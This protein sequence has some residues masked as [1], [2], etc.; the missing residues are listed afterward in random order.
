MCSKELNLHGVFAFS[1]PKRIGGQLIGDEL[2]EEDFVRSDAMRAENFTNEVAS[3]CDGFGGGGELVEPN[4]FVT[5]RDEKAS[6]PLIAR[7]FADRLG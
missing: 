7:T 1:V 4:C 6:V 2:A 3:L 5:E